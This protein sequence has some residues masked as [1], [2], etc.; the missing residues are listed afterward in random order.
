MAAG[1]GLA[2]AAVIGLALRL[3]FGLLYW[4][5]EPLTRD[6]REYLALARS[7][8]A[9]RGLVYDEAILDSPVQPFGRAPGYPAFLALAG[10]GRTVTDD[11]PSS[12][13]IAQSLVGACGVLIVGLLAGQW[14]GARGATIAAWLAASHPLLV[15]TASRAFSEA[16]FWP[17][18]LGAAWLVTAASR[19][20]GRRAAVLATLA[21]VLTGLATLVRPA[22]II[23]L[24]LA[25]LWWLWRRSFTRVV[26]LALGAAL[27]NAPWTLRASER[28]GRFVLVASEGGVTF[29]TGNHPLA[30]GDGDLAANPQLKIASQ[31]LKNAH[32]DLTEEQ[33]EP[34][35]YREALAWMRAHPIDWL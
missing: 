14:A 7:L 9:G 32:P 35:Y 27:V 11:V 13:K 33:M 1:K 26:A 21:G 6:E 2:A 5:H 30:V 18:G 8:A 19:A 22:T 4:V 29:C 34:I 17:I 31:A 10:G 20:G 23:F 16:L 15:A 12:V 3:A 25:A 28:A 24:G